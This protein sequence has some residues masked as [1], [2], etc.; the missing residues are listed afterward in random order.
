MGQK[1]ADLPTPTDTSLTGAGG[2]S[3]DKSADEAMREPRVLPER[4][5]ISGSR[6][7]K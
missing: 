5:S 6:R 1:L 2:L 4:N 7:S 3:W